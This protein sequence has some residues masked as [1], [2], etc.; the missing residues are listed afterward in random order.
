MPPAVRT[1][2]LRGR[3]REMAVNWS[4]LWMGSLGLKLQQTTESYDHPPQIL[5]EKP[6]TC[7]QKNE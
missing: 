2:Y 7:I 5:K 6:T 1:R 4:K 3:R